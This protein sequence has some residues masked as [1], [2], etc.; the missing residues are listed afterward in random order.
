MKIQI[1]STRERIIKLGIVEHSFALN[2]A[3][4]GF[5]TLKGNP[6]YIIA[7]LK[8]YKPDLDMSSGYTNNHAVTLLCSNVSHMSA[9]N[10]I[11]ILE[12]ILSEYKIDINTTRNG[13]GRSALV[14]AIILGDNTLLKWLFSVGANIQSA[15]N[16][17]ATGRVPPSSI[18][19]HKHTIDF[20]KISE[21]TRTLLKDTLYDQVTKS[22]SSK[23]FVGITS[24]GLIYSA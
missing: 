22:M 1:K 12:Y 23:V 11:L 7:Y 16:D 10:R 14:Y 5:G 19:G 4:L 8:K 6:H 9:E 13:H 3:I 21:D 18:Y 15:V 24:T 20:T 17:N 2:S